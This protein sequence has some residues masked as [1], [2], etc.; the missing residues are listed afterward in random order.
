MVYFDQAMEKMRTCYEREVPFC[1]D[2]C[3]FRMDV[4]EFVQRL[5]RGSMTSAFRTFSNGVGFPGLVAKLCP[6]YCQG[7]CPREKTD[8]P[9]RLHMMEE[10]VYRNTSNTK[11][12]SYN[13]PQK[14]GKFAI[15]GGGISGLGC[16]LRLCNKK[17][18]VSLFE[19]S[20]GIGGHLLELMDAEEATSLIER[21]FIYEHYEFHPNERIS[22]PAALLKANGGEFDAVYIATGKD[23]D[24]FGLTPMEDG[25]IPCATDVPGLFLGGS[26]MGADTMHA[27]AQ[28][29]TAATTMEVYHKTGVVK[30]IPA[31]PPTRM[32]L[33]PSALSEKQ[34]P[35]PT[36]EEGGFTKAEAIEEAKR[37]ITCR[38]DACFRHC[39]MFN[40]FDKFP[41]R[42]AEEVRMT[43]YPVT[44]DHDGTVASRLIS[45]CNQC[46]LCAEVCPLDLDMGD[47][48]LSSHQ[49]MAAK[50]SWPWPFHE[51]FIRDMEDFNSRSGL[52]YRPQAEAACAYVFYPGCQL[53]SSDPRYVSKPYEY[54]QGKIENLGL[55]L[56]CCGAPALWGG[57]TAKHEAVLVEIRKNWEALG[58]P[59]FI[60]A[61][62][63]CQQMFSKYLPEIQTVSLYEKLAELGLHPAKQ[64]DGQVSVYDPCACRHQP[65]LN[66]C[67]R[68]MTQEA[69]FENVPLTYEG[70]YAQC[71]SWGGQISLTN[72]PYAD[73]LAK[74][75][76]HENELPYVCYCANCRDI[77]SKQGKQSKH[78]LDLLFDLNDWE[79]QAPRLDQRLAN[80]AALKQ[81]YAPQTEAEKSPKLEVSPE[82]YE[83]LDKEYL[84]LEDIRPIIAAAEE[85]GKYF[86]QAEDQRRIAHGMAGRLTLWVEYEALDEGYR[87]LNAYAHRMHI[88]SDY[89]P[90]NTQRKRDSQPESGLFCHSCLAN[91]EEK[92]THFGYLTYSFSSNIQCCPVCG[93]VYIP[94]SLVKG[95]IAQ[96]EMNLEDK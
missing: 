2:K 76:A 9:I 61:C 65:E 56:G 22:D 73:W 21:E 24:R 55:Y 85:S 86:I 15:V 87:L 7:A 75:R 28:G 78:I 82:L 50:E 96:V 18:Q 48:L 83:K 58:K 26:L 90:D 69:G 45:T 25:S 95:R 51:F 27:L 41:L 11:P 91:V 52:V 63:T 6:G 17:Y 49:M 72:P 33:D 62:P 39:P 80:R 32:V 64:K 81:Q 74:Q 31:I 20:E 59:V 89:E 54:M 38:C 70:Q 1:V 43:V 36:A 44:L 4:R 47:L 68:Q 77:F 53:G 35:E 88:A 67:I 13:L 34:G 3:P 12:N 8:Q 93:Q 79:R 19:A 84:L 14:E 10:A 5:R 94:E 42:L 40:Y 37:C 57:D 66:Q 16:A 71:C 92:K 23:G 29:M 60:Q 30:S 46:G